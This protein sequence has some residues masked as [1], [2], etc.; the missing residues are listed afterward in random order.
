MAWT[1]INP[2][3]VPPPVRS[4]DSHAARVELQE[5]SLL[6]VSG[7]VALDA[8]GAVIGPGDLKQQSDVVFDRLAAILADQDATFDDV[9]SIR[10]YLTDM[11]DLSGYASARSRHLTGTPPTSTTIGVQRLVH[12]DALVEVDVVAVLP[13]PTTS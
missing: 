13:V 11:S 12:P 8:D 4:L 3:A 2:A 1:A 9:V 7:Q 10:T 5:R 6:F